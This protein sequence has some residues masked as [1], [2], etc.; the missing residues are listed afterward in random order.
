MTVG[1]VGVVWRWVRKGFATGRGG[2]AVECRVR[3]MGENVR[4][5]F[6]RATRMERRV[7]A[8]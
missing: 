1:T 2:A 6:A 8:V 3:L 4:L 7:C 5:E